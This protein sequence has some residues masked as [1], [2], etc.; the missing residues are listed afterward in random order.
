MNK[1]PHIIIIGAGPGGATAALQ[2]SYHGIPCTLIDKEIF[3]RDKI[4]GDA[5]SGKSFTILNRINPDILIR[6]YNSS[7]I[8]KSWGGKFVAPNQ[9]HFTIACADEIINSNKN[10]PGLIIRREYFDNF[11]IAEV[12]SRANI[13]LIEGVNIDSFE[14]INDGYLIQ[15]K[16]KKY[17]ATAQLLIVANGAQS[18][19]SRKIAGFEVEP[20]HYC[21]GLRTY[22]KNIEGIDE[23]KLIELHFIKETLPGYFWIFPMQNKE[24]NVGIGML[25]SSISNKKIN[26][27][28]T[29][30][31]LI[32]THPALKDRFKNAT[33]ITPL[34][35]FGLPL[36]SK[37]RKLYGDNYMLI[38]DA[39]HL[40]DP[41]TGEGIGNA[42]Y[43]GW[44]AAE[45]AKI[46]MA[47]NDFS[48]QQLINYDNRVSRT[49]RKELMLSTWI[50]KLVH[51]PNLF[52]FIMNRACSNKKFMD[53]ISAMLL[54]DDEKEKL[55]NPWFLIKAL[56]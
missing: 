37:K 9:K 4:C 26:L 33:H 3:P 2:L 41:L 38:G 48:E 5:I 14:K 21:A 15:S 6:L 53:K 17:N 19:F 10:A 56:R 18:T 11:L 35:G 22:I 55:L 51:Y 29:F 45:Q 39:A 43:S 40:I 32:A 44:L 50:Q 42:M 54:N 20:N 49:M 36:G 28:K 7:F 8:E 23:K 1:Q 47:K 16:D 25:K 30:N 52:N 46:C 12:K 27:K 24:A 31:D 13:K 34:E